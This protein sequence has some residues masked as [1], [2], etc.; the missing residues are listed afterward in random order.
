MAN[1]IVFGVSL[2][3]ILQQNSR[4]QIASKAITMMEMINSNREYTIA[5]VQPELIDQLQVEFLP[6]AIPNFAARETFENLRQKSN[7]RDFFLKMPRSN[8]SI[9]A[10]KLMI[11]KQE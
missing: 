4:N 5:H 1:L 10:T 3:I 8:L 2:S 6:E 11:L 9:L 7:Y